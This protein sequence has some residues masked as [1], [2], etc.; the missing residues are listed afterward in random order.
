MCIHEPPKYP[1]VRFIHTSIQISVN[2][3]EIRLLLDIGTQPS[4]LPQ[5]SY[6]LTVS[7]YRNKLKKHVAETVF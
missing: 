7:G 5:R 2:L 6:F 4:Y 3:A 1:I